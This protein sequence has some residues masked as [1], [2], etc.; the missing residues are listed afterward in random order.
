MSTGSHVVFFLCTGPPTIK[1]LT[2]EAMHAYL[3]VVA[4]TLTKLRLI[5]LGAVSQENNFV[6]GTHLRDDHLRFQTRVTFFHQ[7]RQ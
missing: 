1:A 7:D 5:R 2:T 4:W 6:D 3:V